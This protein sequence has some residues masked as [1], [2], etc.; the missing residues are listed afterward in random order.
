MATHEHRASEIGPGFRLVWYGR[1][2][3]VITHRKITVGNKWP[4][5]MIEIFVEG[6]DEPLHFR[7]GE[8]IQCE[9]TDPPDF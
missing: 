9:G 7:P 4:T 2:Y 1:S 8:A 6:R 5:D 3:E